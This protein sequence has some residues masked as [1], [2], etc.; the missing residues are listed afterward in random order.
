MLVTVPD[1]ALA[2]LS[3]GVLRLPELSLL[4]FDEAHH[5]ARGAAYNC[6]MRAR[7]GFALG[8]RG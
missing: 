7:G 4:V 6:I 2:L 5:A 3:H 8:L 1:V